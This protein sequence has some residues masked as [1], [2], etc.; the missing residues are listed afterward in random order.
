MES[1][2]EEVLFM[3]FQNLEPLELIS[4]SRVNRRW[5]EVALHPRLH[6]F[7]KDFFLFLKDF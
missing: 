2:P 3:I 5:H 7:L 4:L 6:R 1:L